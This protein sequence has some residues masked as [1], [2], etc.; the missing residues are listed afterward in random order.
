MRKRP[1]RFGGV[2][3]ALTILGVMVAM[4]TSIILTMPSPRKSVTQINVQSVQ[5]TYDFFVTETPFVTSA[6][7]FGEHTYVA[8]RWFASGTLYHPRTN[9][10]YAEIEACE[11]EEECSI[12]AAMNQTHVEYVMRYPNFRTFYVY[13]NATRLVVVG[14]V[15]GVSNWTIHDRIIV[16]RD[17]VGDFGAT[18]VY[19]VANGIATYAACALALPY[20][21]NPTMSPTSSPEYETAMPLR[22]VA[23]HVVLFLTFGGYMS[24]FRV[25]TSYLFGNCQSEDWIVF[26][27]MRESGHSGDEGLFV[28]CDTE[29]LS[30]T[31]LYDSIGVAEIWTMRASYSSVRLDAE[32]VTLFGSYNP[33]DFT[34]Y[35]VPAFVKDSPTGWYEAPSP[36]MTVFSP[37]LV[38]IIN[39]IYRYNK[40]TL[41]FVSH[42]RIGFYNPIFFESTQSV[43]M[44]LGGDYEY[45]FDVFPFTNETNPLPDISLPNSVTYG[46]ACCAWSSNGRVSSCRVLRGTTYGYPSWSNPSS[47]GFLLLLDGTVQMSNAFAH[48]NSVSWTSSPISTARAQSFVRFE[49]SRMTYE[50]EPLVWDDKWGVPGDVVRAG[51]MAFA[52]LQRGV[53]IVPS[54]T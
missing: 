3:I 18:I 54:F 38:P 17:D 7:T 12:V 43:C 34:S 6:A 25:A 39:F 4:P 50:S 49:G 2:L 14:V 41:Q 9:N 21:P 8:M 19:E 46:G 27:P 30:A 37:T 10:T 31:V 1:V 35:A 24:S 36:V 26:T 16:E 23:T 42:A 53:C 13:A 45:N 22:V 51:T 11:S 52:A 48:A 5:T 44:P 20:S 33:A 15:Y 28:P 40:Q 32:Y 47:A 29:G